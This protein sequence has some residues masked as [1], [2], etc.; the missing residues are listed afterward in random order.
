MLLVAIAA[1]FMVSTFQPTVSFKVGN[2]V[3]NLWVAD[4]EEKREKGL[5][6]VAALKPQQGMIFKFDSEGEWGIWMKDMKI[7]IDII[8][9][10][11]QKRVVHVVKNALPEL[12][13]DLTFR[14]KEPARYVVEL[15]MGSVENAGIRKGMMTTFDETSAG[16]VRW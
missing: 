11:E 12:G 1:S 7:P 15:P 13:T 4:T 10:N 14:P 5:S 2:G 6:G 16:E 3:Y 9:I 8:W